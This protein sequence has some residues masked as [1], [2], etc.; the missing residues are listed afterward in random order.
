MGSWSTSKTLTFHYG[1]SHN[2]RFLYI[3]PSQWHG[4]RTLILSDHHSHGLQLSPW[5]AMFY[6][7]LKPHVVYFQL[8]RY[9]V[10]CVTSP[11][12]HPYVYQ[13]LASTSGGLSLED[14]IHLFG[15]WFLT[16][17][18]IRWMGQWYSFVIY[19]TRTNTWCSSTERAL[20]VYII[21]CTKYVWYLTSIVL[22]VTPKRT[23][24]W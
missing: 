6:I 13:A 12:L 24:W 22:L 10:H 11:W 4:T 1:K 3:A 23:P 14:V 17:I 9:A 2:V 15:F 16:F 8:H 20:V 7:S 18:L 5:T 19:S 21:H